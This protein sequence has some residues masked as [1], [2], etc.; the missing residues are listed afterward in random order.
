M[1]TDT[2]LQMVICHASL[3]T[4]ITLQCVSRLTR[5]RGLEERRVRCLCRGKVVSRAIFL[6]LARVLNAWKVYKATPRNYANSWTRARRSEERM[7]LW[8]PAHT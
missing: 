5:Q 3:P 8:I 2:V 4:L 6:L 7:L 1:D